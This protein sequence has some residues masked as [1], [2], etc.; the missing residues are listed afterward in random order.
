[1]ATL[2]IVRQSAF[3]TNDFAQCIEVICDNDVIALVDDG[4]Y[5]LQHALMNNFSQSKRS[6]N[7]NIQVNV[8]T[9]HAK[10]RAITVDESLF[11]KISMNDLVSI[12]FSNDRVITW[13]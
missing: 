9:E 4:C 10:A 3:N 1:M 7:K 2:H 11:T 13:Q 5:N 12:T 6:E 8:L